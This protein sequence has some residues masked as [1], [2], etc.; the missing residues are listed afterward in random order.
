MAGLRTN[1]F[2]YFHSITDA[3]SCKSNVVNLNLFSRDITSVS[4]TPTFAFIAPNLCDDGHDA[5]C[6]TGPVGGLTAANQF[7]ETW[8][9]QILASPA[10]RKDGLLIIAFD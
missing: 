4:D 10:Y 5:V 2:V 9:P 6:V 1:P 8:V 3:P 7:L